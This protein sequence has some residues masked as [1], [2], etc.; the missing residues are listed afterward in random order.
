MSKVA[1]IKCTSYK[2]EAVNAAVARGIEL[3]GGIGQFVKAGE[4]VLLKPN[5]VA[6]DP[7]ER[8]ATTHPAVMEG[9]AVLLKEA[10][11]SITYGDSPGFH[12]PLTA[13]K[14]AGLAEVADRLGIGLADFET[15]EEVFFEEAVQNRSLRIAKGV[16]EADAM[17]SLPKLKTHGFQKMTGAIKNQFGCIPGPLKGE[18]HVKLPDA[19]QFAR[20]L[21]DINSF[22]KPRLY[23]M[24]GIM[25]MEGNGPRGGQPT[26]MNVLLFSSDPVAL[27]A[28]ICRMIELDPA[29]VPTTVMGM[30]AGL[31]TYLEEEIELVG[32]D[33]AS[34]IKEGFDVE[35]R[36]LRPYRSGWVSKLTNKLVVPKPF[37]KEEKCVKCGVCVLMCP[38]EGKA[39]DWVD[40]NMKQPPVYE[41]SK[42]IRCY[43][44]QEMCPESA[45][46]L[47]VPPLRR[48]LDRKYRG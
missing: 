41:Y 43:C 27:D 23:I 24:D 21:V 30:E 1:I 31:G 12:A 10:D 14:K 8:C 7:P 18:M 34:F 35:R 6:A 2:K 47:D 11:L 40:G 39:V 20:M 26:A 25:A 38:V 9:I 19:E 3:I 42:C 17:I 29:Y 33:L 37:I 46:E 44:C 36:P 13:A 32:D 5:L 22:V 45:I 16:M 15:D 4:K 48:L 28:T